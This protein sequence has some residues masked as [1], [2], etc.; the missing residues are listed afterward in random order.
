MCFDSTSHHCCMRSAYV[1]AA[2]TG[3][4]Y[5]VVPRCWSPE[6]CMVTRPGG[7]HP[8]RPHFWELMGTAHAPVVMCT[9][10]PPHPLLWHYA[11]ANCSGFCVLP[12]PGSTSS[13]EQFLPLALPVVWYYSDVQAPAESA[14]AKTSHLIS[15]R[16]KWVAGWFSS[17]RR[18]SFCFAF[19]KLEW[20]AA[21]NFP[22]L[23]PKNAPTFA[24]ELAILI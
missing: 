20:W 23:I 12:P 11:S 9:V 18:C 16:S 8:E 10:A 3:L 4:V 7:I 15:G 2:K 5:A 22:N 1:R 19:I 17:Q 13:H 6:V 24:D 14:C 21:W